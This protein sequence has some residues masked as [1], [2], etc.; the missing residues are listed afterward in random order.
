MEFIFFLNNRKD[1]RIFGEN[2]RMQKFVTSALLICLTLGCSNWPT[3]QQLRKPAGIISSCYSHAS[4]FLQHDLRLFSRKK[5]LKQIAVES[6]LLVENL[7]YLKQHE[8][9]HFVRGTDENRI[10]QNIAAEIAI[11]KKYFLNH[12]AKASE[13]I[14]H[15]IDL[16]VKTEGHAEYAYE[17]LS[18]NTVKGGRQYINYLVSQNKFFINLGRV[19]EPPSLKKRLLVV[20][21]EIIDLFLAYAEKSVGYFNK[22]INSGKI[23]TPKY[24]KELEKISFEVEKTI[25]SG[26]FGI[27][28]KVK[29]HE[30]GPDAIHLYPHLFFNGQARDDLIIKFANRFKVSKALKVFKIDIWDKALK[31]EKEETMQFLSTLEQNGMGMIHGSEILFNE[32][33]GDLPYLIKPLV[34]GHDVKALAKEQSKLSGIQIKRL[35]EDIFH[36]TLKLH[37]FIGIHLDLKVENLIWDPVTEHWSMYELT[38][39]IGNN[40][41]FVA[42]GFEGY[43]NMVRVALKRYGAQ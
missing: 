32:A 12:N 19:P 7:T 5:I 33:T 9:Y 25:G 31:A 8:L 41:T 20:K 6:A 28:Y 15:L 24:A 29:I 16:W 1:R 27:I 22:K 26:F 43:V 34:T 35:E 18:E 37:E 11:F 2:Y 17:F 21:A 3:T 42:N 10:A 36:K 13:Q 4:E 23:L 30:F 40:N 14:M 39:T 38:Q